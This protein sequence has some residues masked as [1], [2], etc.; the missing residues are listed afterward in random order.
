VAIVA[1]AVQNDAA[2]GQARLKGHAA[3]DQRGRGTG[4]FCAVEH[5]NERSLYDPGYFG[6]GT[7]AVNI[8]AV[9]DSSVAFHQS[10]IIAGGHADKAIAQRRAGHKKGVQVSLRGAGCQMRARPRQYSPGLF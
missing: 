10:E 2:D 4:H 8:Q 9:K 3:F 7:G 5:Q 1:R 6:R